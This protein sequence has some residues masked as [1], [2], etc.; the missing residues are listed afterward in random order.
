MGKDV[1][2]KELEILFLTLYVLITRLRLENTLFVKMGQSETG[3]GPLQIFLESKKI[4]KI[5]LTGNG[6]WVH[7]E[8][9]HWIIC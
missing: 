1:L 7:F 9:K 5:S 4:F 8:N 2:K 6:C 3:I